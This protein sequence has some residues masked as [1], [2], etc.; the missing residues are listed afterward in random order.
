MRLDAALP[1]LSAAAARRGFA[2]VLPLPLPLPLACP[3]V[4]LRC[5]G[6]TRPLPWSSVAAAR[7]RSTWFYVVLRGST[8]LYVAFR[9]DQPSRTGDG[10]PP[11]VNRSNTRPASIT[12]DSSVGSGQWLAPTLSRMPRSVYDAFVQCPSR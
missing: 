5:R 3:A 4:V 11:S 8:W 12:I 7:R 2:M 1:W 6:S 10:A 9:A